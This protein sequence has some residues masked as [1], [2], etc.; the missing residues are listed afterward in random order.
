MPEQ[1]FL[2]SL[3]RQ[4]PHGP[5]VGNTREICGTV[6]TFKKLP[7]RERYE[8]AIRATTALT[9]VV[10]DGWLLFVKPEVLP[11]TR[12]LIALSDANEDLFDDD[13]SAQA[14]VAIS[15]ID[16]Y[17]DGLLPMPDRLLLGDSR[18][19]AVRKAFAKG[20]HTDTQ[21]IAPNVNKQY[22]LW[23]PVMC[24]MCSF[25]DMFIDERFSFRDIHDMNEM[26]D[27]KQFQEMVAYDTDDR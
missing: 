6:V 27:L 17:T 3:M 21:K 5:F 19:R 23:R 16:Y 2:G 8:L 4:W 14:A 20:V 7:I 13:L 26:L 1:T 24:E 15:A 22:F 12:E 10:D 25:A 18:H 11:M 9:N